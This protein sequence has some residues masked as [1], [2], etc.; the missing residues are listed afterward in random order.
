MTKAQLK[1]A[2]TKARSNKLA[3]Q[4]AKL[5]AKKENSHVEDD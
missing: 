1:Q 3:A 4:N 5:M 2:D